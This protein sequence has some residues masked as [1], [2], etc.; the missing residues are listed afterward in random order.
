VGPL[1]TRILTNIN[2]VLYVL[3]NGE[4]FGY[5]DYTG[6]IVFQGGYNPYGNVYGTGEILYDSNLLVKTLN[7]K[8]QSLVE[9]YSGC[10]ANPLPLFN[11]GGEKEVHRLQHWTNMDNFTEFDGKANGP[12]V[13]PTRAGYG[14]LAKIMVESCVSEGPPA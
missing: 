8:E 1:F 14:R 11:P 5:E 9:S 2:A 6:Q 4:E 7:E 12:D 3:R 13:H 10:F